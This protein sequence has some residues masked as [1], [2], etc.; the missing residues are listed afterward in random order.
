MALHCWSRQEGTCK[1]G[2]RLG[3]AKD[4]SIAPVSGPEA[5]SCMQDVR[6]RT[7]RYRTPGYQQFSYANPHK[8]TN[9]RKFRG[10]RFTYA[11]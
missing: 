7:R 4:Q 6:L 11:A 3:A 2:S 5:I 9:A 8:L 10:V 1:G